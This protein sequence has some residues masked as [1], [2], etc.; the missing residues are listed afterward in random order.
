MTNYNHRNKASVEFYLER[1]YASNIEE[2]VAFVNK[3]LENKQQSVKEVVG[4]FLYH[5]L[6]SENSSL[7]KENQLKTKTEEEYLKEKR[8]NAKKGIKP[9]QKK[10]WLN[11]GYNESDAL[12][13]QSNEQRKRSKRCVEYWTSRGYSDDEARERI[14]KYQNNNSL[15][16][17][18]ERYGKEYGTKKY[19]LWINKQKINS[20]RCIEYW[21]NEGYS[22]NEAQI[23]VSEFQSKYGS[24]GFNKLLKNRKSTIETDFADYLKSKVFNVETD[25]MIDKFFP[26]IV[27]GNLIVEV[28]G[29]FWHMN[30]LM[31]KSQDIHKIKKVNAY[32][33]WNKDQKRVQRL[34]DLGYDVLIV[35]ESELKKNGFDHYL[36]MIA[37]KIKNRL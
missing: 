30:P 32:E 19:D 12:T 20:K 25:M 22:I 11:L 27:I 6:R 9:N 2:A 21:I 26:D 14:S 28:Y 37:N 10:Y 8:K 3:F 18:I 16:K 7:R 36:K 13:K 24:S 1:N 35:W 31:Y 5:K 4:D 17:F 23:K 29:D 15:D 33:I 34:I